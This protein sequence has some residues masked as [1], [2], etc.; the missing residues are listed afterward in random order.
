MPEVGETRVRKDGLAQATWDGQNWVETELDPL[1]GGAPAT[2]SNAAPGAGFMAAASGRPK[3]FAKTE[4]NLAKMDEASQ[5]AQSLRADAN[6]FRALNERVPTGGIGGMPGIRDVRA[7][8]DPRV[9]EMK[10]IVEKMTPSM[11]E[12]GSGAMSDRDVEMYRA[13]VVGLDKLGPTNS[14]LAKVIDAGARRTGDYAAFKNEWARRY[15][16]LVGSDEAWLQYAED[17]PLFSAGE[18]GTTVNK[19][20]PWREYFGLETLAKKPVEKAA[21]ETA[22][23]KKPL[24]WSKSLSPEVRARLEEFAGSTA[25]GGTA[26][27]PFAPTSEAEYNKLPPGAYYLHPSGDVRRKK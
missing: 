4:E 6:R 16:T 12:A 14:A 1:S 11:R 15:N 20:T 21:G 8:L 27:N 26:A 13:S 5:Q 2:V 24:G 9:G 18:T 17:N 3:M 25:K 23:S 19:V 22:R 10:A 7:M